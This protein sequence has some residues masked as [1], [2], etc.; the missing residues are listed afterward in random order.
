MV[1]KYLFFF[2]YPKYLDIIMIDFGFH[3]AQ[4]GFIEHKYRHNSTSPR[5]VKTDNA[6]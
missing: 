5:L 1:Q 3:M 6:A 2:T 4:S